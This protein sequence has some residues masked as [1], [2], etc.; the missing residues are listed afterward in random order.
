MLDC[1][2]GLTPASPEGY[3]A[4][5]VAVD[6]FTKWVEAWPI[7]NV[8]SHEVA[9]LLHTE[10]VCR[11]GKPQMVRTDGGAEFRGAFVDYCAA[12]G[13]RHRRV[14]PHHPQA[15]GQVERVNGL[16]RM[17]FRLA[18]A[19]G[20]DWFNA[21]PEVLAGLRQLPSRTHDI[22]PFFAQFKQEPV[23]PSDVQV[24]AP[25][26]ALGWW[27]PDADME[28]VSAAFA[29]QWA[30]MLPTI[31]AKLTRGDSAMKRQ[32]ERKQALRAAGVVHIFAPGDQVLLQ[33]YRPGKMQPRARGPYTFVRY[34]AGEGCTARVSSGARVFTCSAAQ[35]IPVLGAAEPQME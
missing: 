30:S 6:P 2:L 13:I 9:W 1:L 31:R 10:I 25:E 27:A 24:W 14:T 33:E 32:Y 20:I 34:G 18:K 4:L 22:T 16:L 7:R 29:E 19:A 26:D 21:Y 15:A 12:Y 17:G 11:Y 3:T 28:A 35:L 5:L 23:H 8:C